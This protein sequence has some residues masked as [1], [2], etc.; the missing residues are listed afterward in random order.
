MQYPAFRDQ[1][2]PIGSGMVESANKNVVEA[3]LKGPGMHWERSHVNPMLA[4]RAAI[5]NERWQEMWRQALTHHR[6]WQA[7]LRS[8]RANPGV[9]ASLACAEDSSRASPSA[10]SAPMSEHPSPPPPETETSQPNPCRLPR[11][12]TRQIAQQRVNWSQ[13]TSSDANADVCL[14]GMPLV[15]FR[16]H[17]PKRYCSDRCRQRAY[18]KRQAT[19]FSSRPLASQLKPEAQRKQRH[20]RSRQLFVRRDAQTCPCGTPLVRQRGHRPREY[21]SERCRQRAHRE[22]HLQAES[23]PH[24]SKATSSNASSICSSISEAPV[25]T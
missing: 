8:A 4:L 1:V 21:C 10:P 15:R 13:H 25:H 22:R 17:R 2:W 12:H 20:P 7:L 3:R 9:P 14:C 6:K 19:L 18:R 23:L 5:C 11:R 16:G 24:W